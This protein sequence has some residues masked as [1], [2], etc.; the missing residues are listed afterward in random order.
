MDFHNFFTIYVFKIKEFIFN[1]PT[2]L[3]CLSDLKSPGRLPVQ[4]VFGCT[5]DCVLWIFEI[6]LLAI[7]VFEVRESFTD[8][9]FELSC[10]GDFEN[11]GQLPVQEVFEIT[12][13]R[14]LKMF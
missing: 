3:P 4:Q 13:I 14:W 11:S 1:I 8:I 12:F 2:E 5:G 7:Y 6:S 9:P 10:L